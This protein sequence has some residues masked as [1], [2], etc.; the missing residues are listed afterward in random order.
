MVGQPDQQE[1]DVAAAATGTPDGDTAP[2]G[3]AARALGCL[4][5]D[6]ANAT[7]RAGLEEAP[8]VDPRCPVHGGLWTSDPV[9]SR[10]G[11]QEVAE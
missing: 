4:C 10:P 11:G 1:S 3:Q 8:C 5:P 2:G 6:L 9:V 7:Y